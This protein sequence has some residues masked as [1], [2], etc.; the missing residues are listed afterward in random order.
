MAVFLI[1]L[2][3]CSRQAVGPQQS[4]SEGYPSIHLDYTVVYQEGPF[5]VREAFLG[6]RDAWDWSSFS[7]PEARIADALPNLGFGDFDSC[8]EQL[9]TADWCTTMLA[10]ARVDGGEDYF[11]FMMDGLQVGNALLR[12]NGKTLWTGHVDGGLWRA[13]P[14]SRQV[15]DE[16]AVEYQDAV[17]DQEGRLVRWV[18]SVLLTQGNTALDIVQATGHDRAFAPCGI[19]G[20]LV[21]VAVIHGPEQGRADHFLVFQDR[22]VAGPYDNV[23]NQYCCWDGPPIQVHCD[24]KMVDFFVEKDGGWY[25]VQ[26]GHLPDAP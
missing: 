3:A 12:K 10:L 13:I 24:G 4:P 25:H 16:I 18:E 26:A 21:Y 8:Y 23:F 11:Q 17:F 7:M 9:R 15:G 19:D 22:K 5:I 2:T 14:S 20:E 1:L 6:S